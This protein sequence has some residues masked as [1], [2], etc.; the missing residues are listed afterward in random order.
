MGTALLHLMEQQRKEACTVSGATPSSTSSIAG[1]QEQEPQPKARRLRST[2]S[3]AGEQEQE[4][5]PKPLPLRAKAHNPQD[6]TEH[7][8]RV[9]IDQA[10]RATAHQANRDIEEVANKGTG[11]GQARAKRM[12]PQPRA[13]KAKARSR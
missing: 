7:D 4:P 10:I 8:V 2:S 13:C 5:Q 6:L 9:H 12:L 3:M 1:E 11:K